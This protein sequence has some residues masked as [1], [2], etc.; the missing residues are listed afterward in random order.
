M[1]DIWSVMMA[2]LV[3]VLPLA[4]AWLL[5]GWTERKRVFGAG[6]KGTGRRIRPV[7]WP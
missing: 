6:P 2:L 4:L 5:L 3:L 1:S 7:R